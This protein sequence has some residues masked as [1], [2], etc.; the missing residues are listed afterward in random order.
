MNRHE[1]ADL[2][3][4][5]TISVRGRKSKVGSKTLYLPPEDP[6]DFAAFWSSLPD[7]LGAA[8]LRA[9][10]RAIL[11]SRG[12]GRP[13]LAM[14]GAHVL[15]VGMGPGLIHMMR[16]GLLTGIAM[17]GAG[18]IHDVE[19]GLWGATSE[20][21]A[22]ELH[23]GRFGMARE[24]AEAVNGAAIDARERHEGFGE[25]L[26]RRLLSARPASGRVSVLAAA[27][28]LGLPATVHVAIGT[29]IVHQ[30]PGFD[31]AATGEASARDFRI[32][33]G[34]ATQLKGGTV[35]NLGSAVVLPEVFLKA[36][37]VARNLGGD[38]TGI[39]TAVFDFQRH[40]RPME[41][42]VRRPTSGVGKGYYVIGH[43]EIL[44]PLLIQ[45]CMVER[46]RRGGRRERSR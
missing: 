42:V 1:E 11:A 30:H 25:A 38:M 20:D 28:G 16:E 15:K 45:A 27:R 6:G 21:V 19:L 44:L 34:L 39:T 33:C 2:S 14:V 41:N 22:A 5:R 23:E 24:T 10:V 12:R 35:L 18:A 3:K 46:R 36:Y 40:Y 9:V 7:V 37:S 17:T 13:I 32:L 8:D 43:H 26:G 4:V 31:G 29:D